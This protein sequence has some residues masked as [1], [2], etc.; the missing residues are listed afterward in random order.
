MSPRLR[1]NLMLLTVAVI[2]GFAVPVI[3]FTF[4]YFDTITFLTYR[5][6]LT[7]LI[8]IPLLAITQPRT[9]SALA[10][11]S[12]REWLTFII[13]G[14]L[15][16]TLQLGLLFWGL[17]LTSSLDGSIIN[18]ASPILVSL[19]GYYFL[20]EHITPR[21]KLGQL[22]A[23]IGTIFVIIQPVFESGR[24]FSGTLIGN[25]LV[26]AGT[27][28]WVGYVLLTKRQLG[29]L[30]PL[31][32]T[33]NMFFLGFVSMSVIALIFKNPITIYFSLLT[34]PPAAHLGVLYMVVFSGSLAYWL[35]QKAQ[36]IVEVSEANVFL[37]LPPVFTAPLAY[38]W[39]GEHITWPAILG[40]AII[41][42]GVYVAETRKSIS[43]QTPG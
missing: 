19:A 39:L 21:E 23:F 17:D 30:S 9:W 2:W 27:L 28:A 38:F 12:R 42:A 41:A 4:N 26:L 36:K 43:P 8:L 25:F 5:F 20:K 35:Y 29:H 3:K 14:L 11:L 24:I 6:F 13:G 33:T 34:S 22:I 16:S 7:S 40:S 32:L 10:S 18:S 31:L 1:A 37:F 15:G